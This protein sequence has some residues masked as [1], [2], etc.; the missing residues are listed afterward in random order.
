MVKS[1]GSESMNLLS[2]A[3]KLTPYE[4]YSILLLTEA[5]ADMKRGQTYDGRV[6][7]KVSAADIA[8]YKKQQVIDAIEFWIKKGAP[9][10]VEEREALLRKLK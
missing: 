5:H 1:T 9:I 6:K 8:L 10:Y 4:C 2:I 3:P 7:W